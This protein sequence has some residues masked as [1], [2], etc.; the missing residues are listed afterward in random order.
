MTERSRTKAPASVGSGEV[1][2]PPEGPPA[3]LPAPGREFRQSLWVQA[4]ELIVDLGYAY[5]AHFI[6]GQKL[7]ANAKYLGIPRVVLPVVASAG[8]ATLALFGLNQLA[9]LFGFG[10]AIIVALER[11]FDPIGQANAHTEKG[12]R[13]LT[14][15]KDLRN[16]RN[17]RLRGASTDDQLERELA[18]IRKRADD[19]RL[20]EPRQIPGWAFDEARR[21]V[22]DGQSSYVDD[23][24]WQAPPGDL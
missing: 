5:R 3:H 4:S 8:A 19:L 10:G 21:Q 15:W 7:R 11:Y 24:L 22:R 1:N 18:Q 13:L 16:F 20:T 9:V 23:P 14:V 17:V 12:D 2:E 6:V